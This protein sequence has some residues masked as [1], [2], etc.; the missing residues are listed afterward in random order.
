MDLQGCIKQEEEDM[1]AGGHEFQGRGM[2]ET[3][4]PRNVKLEIWYLSSWS[5]NYVISTCVKLIFL[6]LA[7][8][9]QRIKKKRVNHNRQE[10]RHCL[11]CLLEMEATP[12]ITNKV[13]G[14]R[15]PNFELALCVRSTFFIPKQQTL[16]IVLFVLTYWLVQTWAR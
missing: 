13:K 4:K 10:I 16:T 11:W 6:I 7:T 3:C 5:K 14:R 8:I 2:I 1:V 9:I 12:T 15:G